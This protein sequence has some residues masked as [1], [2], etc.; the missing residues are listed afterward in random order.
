MENTLSIT[1]TWR[2]SRVAYSGLFWLKG[3]RHRENSA[4]FLDDVTTLYYAVRSTPSTHTHT[5]THTQ[6][7]CLVVMGVRRSLFQ[8]PGGDKLQ[9]CKDQSDPTNLRNIARWQQRVFHSK[10]LWSHLR[11]LQSGFTVA[12][13]HE[14]GQSMLIVCYF[15]NCS[16]IKH[17]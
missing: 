6:Q 9:R 17:T 15:C 10:T 12:Y 13:K 14:K 16:V 8:I 5:H 4:F 1:W 3:W 11:K 2:R 7:R